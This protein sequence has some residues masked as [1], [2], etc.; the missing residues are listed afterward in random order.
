MQPDKPSPDA[1]NVGVIT[2]EDIA[3]QKEMVGLDEP[4]QTREF[5]SCLSADTIRNFALNVGDD[6][7]LYVDSDYARRTRW[8]APIAPAIMMAVVNEPLRGER[9]PKD[10]RARARGLF[11]GCQMFMSGGT[12]N[13]YR[14]IYAGDTIFSF[15]GEDSVEVKASEFGG[16]TVHIVRRYVKFNQ[17]GE[18]VGIYR[19]LRIIAERKTAREKG[20]Y[21]ALEMAHY[22]KDEVKA[23]DADYLGEAP[24]GGQGRFWEDV[25]EGDELS[26]IRKGPLTVTDVF[27]AHCAGYG[28]APY[29][30]LATGRVAAKDRQIMRGMYSRNDQGVYD[31]EAR[32]HWD[33]DLAKQVGNPEAYD[34][35]LQREFWLHHLLTDWAGD[36]GFVVSQRDEIRKFNYIGD[37]QMLTGRVVRK[38]AADAGHMVDVEI[39]ATNQRG[40][41]TALAWATIALPSREVGAVVLPEVPVELA[42][43]AAEFLKIHNAGW[44]GA[45]GKG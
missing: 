2:D 38:Y 8:G 9:L 32:V 44:G 27:L 17:R 6:N 35:G 24:R 28:F 25:A 4:N 3:L 36:D 20:K 41:K 43:K 19:A 5:H 15:E 23:I 30:M 10:M 22:S 37:L 45:G 13:W 31:T 29:R 39:C 16:R 26:P 14:P 1:K 34:W 21:A 7:P 12:W 40:E 18:V 42:R 33:R 11:P